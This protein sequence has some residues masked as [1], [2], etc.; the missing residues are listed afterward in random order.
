MINFV[1]AHFAAFEVWPDKNELG[2]G[3]DTVRFA[4]NRI[5]TLDRKATPQAAPSLVEAHEAAP[6]LVSTG[7]SWHCLSLERETLWL[8]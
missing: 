8:I 4:L 2:T 6:S 7:L 5:K 1:P 3:P